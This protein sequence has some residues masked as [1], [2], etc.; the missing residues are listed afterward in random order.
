MNDAMPSHAAPARPAPA[1]RPSKRPRPGAKK[2][3]TARAPARAREPEDLLMTAG[4]IARLLQCTERW[5]SM[6]VNNEGWPIEQMGTGA[7]PHVFRIADLPREVEREIMTALEKPFAAVGNADQ[8]RADAGALAETFHAATPAARAAA[9]ERL[10][11]IDEVQRLA[12]T[13]G[14]LGKAREAVAK[15]MNDRGQVGSERT[16]KRWWGM[17][18]KLP[19]AQWLAA[20]LPD[21]AIGAPA[22]EVE[23]QLWAF[24]RREYFRREA[25]SK[26][27]THRQAEKLALANGWP[28]PSYDTVSRRLDEVP[29]LV[30]LG[31]REGARALDAA[32]PA[33]TRDPTCF[34]V[35]EAV[36]GDGLKFD[37]VWTRFGDRR[38]TCTAT[39]WFWQDIRSRK[40]LAWELGETENTDLFRLATYHLSKVCNPRH[41]WIDNT[42]AAANKVMTAGAK[43]RYRF[44][45]QLAEGQGI[46]QQA[47]GATVHFTQPGHG[48]SKPIERAFGDGGLHK[49]VRL[50][51]SIAGK[52]H[53][54]ATAIPAE[55][56]R[57]LIAEAVAEHNARTGR[58]GQFL[59]GSSYD[60]A[61]ARGCERAPP[62]QTSQRAQ[63]LFL[64][65]REAVTVSR[66]GTVTLKA[67]ASPTGKNRYHSAGAYQ[68]IGQ[69]VI[70]YFDPE[71]LGKG[72]QLY[73]TEGR[74]L[75]DAE[76]LPTAAF[77]DTESAREMA[78]L[79]QRLK[80]AAAQ[81]ADALQGMSRLEWQQLSAGL[82]AE[83]PPA[84]PAPVGPTRL[85]P[86]V[87][88][89]GRGA[90]AAAVAAGPGA[91]AGPAIVE[92]VK[93]HA[94]YRAKAREL[95]TLQQ[96]AEDAPWEAEAED[97][98]LIK[99]IAELVTEMAEWKLSNGRGSQKP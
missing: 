86:G 32:M 46:L 13:L 96:W 77:N 69:Q 83:T 70:A 26:R 54:A 85:A 87:P 9:L 1:G 19:R 91:A 60:E 98:P 41:V 68:L 90:A 50:H 53:S 20:L 78:K 33:M 31:T 97:S 3:Q 29:A 17:V 36:N 67:G 35:G 64:Y 4:Q 11:A 14:G 92:P 48:Q 8:M 89:P 16:L 37:T 40:I 59:E 5:I 45:Q 71:D 76:R 55:E 57:R 24:I 84:P 15:A 12:K 74:Y 21:A 25:P 7:A 28:V 52:G 95:G 27:H 30:H 72:V 39:A 47:F 80:K 2:R 44:K 34:E 18:H 63:A 65:S 88:A 49:A 56:L 51:A 38:A 79:R 99:R 43:S 10:A 22:L 81:E 82:V 23:P 61:W 58:T 62:E 42:T 66:K 6:R 75:C 94:W 73:N 93:D